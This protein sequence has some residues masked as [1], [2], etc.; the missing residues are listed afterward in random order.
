MISD[1]DMYT[2]FSKNHSIGCPWILTFLQI[3]PLSGVYFFYL[4]TSLNQNRILMFLNKNCTAPDEIVEA[5]YL[6]QTSSQRLSCLNNLF[7][8]SSKTLKWSSMITWGKLNTNQWDIILVL[9]DLAFN[10]TDLRGLPDGCGDFDFTLRLDFFP[11]T[12]SRS[13]S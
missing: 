1:H 10:V 9:T 5:V 8:T 7:F 6:A 13:W 2:P 11:H 12:R 4:S 3:N